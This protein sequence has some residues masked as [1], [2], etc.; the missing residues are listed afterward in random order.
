MWTC[1]KRSVVQTSHDISE[2]TS[3][4]NISWSNLPNSWMSTTPTKAML[5]TWKFG[6]TKGWG[7]SDRKKKWDGIEV[8]FFCLSFLN[9]KR[10]LRGVWEKNDLLLLLLLFSPMPLCFK[11]R[12]PCCF[13]VRSSFCRV[14][15]QEVRV[16]KQGKPQPGC[17]LWM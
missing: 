1:L 14:E 6:I 7:G 3:S 12:D 11:N 5:V 2:K 10:K 15:V 13:L 8:V 9:K 16:N 17:S 4:G